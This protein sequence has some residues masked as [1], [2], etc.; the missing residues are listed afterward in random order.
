MKQIQIQRKTNRIIKYFTEQYNYTVDQAKMFVAVSA[1]ETG[2]W[3]SSLCKNNKNYFGMKYAGIRRT[4]AIGERDGF[5]CYVNIDNSLKDFVWY[6][7]YFGYK[8]DYGGDLW[9]F[10]WE[11]DEN[12][13]F[14]AGFQ[15]YYNSV[16]DYYQKLYSNG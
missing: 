16:R 4:T 9:K 10:V 8:T 7:R 3:R 5:A 1:H 12:G 13:Y 2:F 6:L 14:E 11:M 15:D